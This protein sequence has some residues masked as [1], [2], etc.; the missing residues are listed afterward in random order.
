MRIFFHV[1]PVPMVSC[2]LLLGNPWCKRVGD[3]R[4]SQKNSYTISWKGQ[5]ICSV[6]MRTDV[7][8]PDW[9]N[10]LLKREE[11]QEERKE[12]VDA[13]TSG[14]NLL[15]HKVQDGD[16]KGQRWSVFKT[17]CMIKDRACKMIIDGCSFTNAISKDVVHALGLSM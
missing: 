9:K 11:Q 17:Q 6:P 16:A 7:L 1:C 2:H 14:L 4:S 13:P 10:H 15:V 12:E 3:V 5:Q 8:Q